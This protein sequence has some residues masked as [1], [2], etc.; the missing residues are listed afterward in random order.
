MILLRFYEFR[1]NS[2][3]THLYK[4]K[5][6]P[7]MKFISILLYQIN[8]ISSLCISEFENKYLQL[9]VFKVKNKIDFDEVILLKIL[10]LLI[11]FFLC[12]FKIY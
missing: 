8:K 9:F 4:K 3:Y 11:I 5:T 1:Q 6:L 12:Y 2:N 7:Y 10:V